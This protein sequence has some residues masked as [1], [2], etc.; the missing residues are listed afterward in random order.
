[1]KFPWRCL[2]VVAAL[3][4]G[5][6]L[7]VACEEEEEESG[8]AFTPTAAASPTAEV[9]P[10]AT[11]TLPPPAEVA[12]PTT[13]APPPTEELASPTPEVTEEPPQPT[14]TEVPPEPTEEPPPPP[15]P[16]CVPSGQA[17]N[18][19]G[20]ETCVEV[21]RADCSYRPDVNGQPT[22][23]NDAP[24]PTHSF[25]AVI[26]GDNRGNWLTLPEQLYD[27]KCVDF[28]GLVTSYRGKP[29]IELTGPLQ[30]SFCQ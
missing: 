3:M 30:A 18:Y 9:T 24:Y 1:M 12:S 4:A 2:L 17:I 26:W 21:A 10:V 20:T 5:L 29:Q 14:P 27:G 13:E 25:T 19:I 6:L 15:P 7:A 11:P 28:T 23:C 8:L 22:F 16:T